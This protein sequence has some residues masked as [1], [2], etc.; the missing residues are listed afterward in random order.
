M[1][2]SVAFTSST[3]DALKA[4]LLRADGQEDLCYALW[5]PGQGA[6]RLTALVSDPILPIDGERQVHGNASTTG[7]YLGRAIKL[8]NEKGAGVAFLHSHPWPGWQDMSQDDTNTERRQ[9]PAIKAT[10]GMPLVGL[11]LGT[12]GSWSARLWV[13]SAPKTY[14]RRWCESVRVVGKNGLE[15]TFNDKLLRPPE[16]REELK[17][18]ISAWGE[19]TQQRVARLRFGVVGIG[20]VG[21][22]VAECLARMGVENIK[23]IDYDRVKR[24]NLDRLLHAGIED[25]VANRLKVDLIG[26]ALQKSA[27]AAQ[28]T[29]QKCPVAVTE[30]EGFREALDCDI[31]FSCVDRPWPRHVLNYIAYAYLVPIIDGGILIRT[32]AGQLRNASWRSHAVYPGR[33]CLQCIGQY[34]PDFVNVERQGHLDDPTY[35]ESLPADHT[36]RRNE[37]VFPFSAHLAASLMM[38]ALHVVLNPMKISDIGEQIYHFVDGTVDCT[39]DAACYEGCYFSS[40]IARGDSE[41]LPITGVDPGASKERTKQKKPDGNIAA[42]RRKIRDFLKLTRR[43]LSGD[44]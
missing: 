20:S 39:R 4:H 19:P 37:N 13:K 2:Y 24:H 42:V 30:V 15:V 31:L 33:R 23:L 28:S 43:R 32:R 18:T 17:R 29:V 16:F 7:D 27:T 1:R 10:T 36:L 38:Q 14:E 41:G 40:I 34:D 25:A 21:S 11:T 35:I 9:A 26:T 44:I 3:N 6:N 5:Q 22:I 8:A 12:D